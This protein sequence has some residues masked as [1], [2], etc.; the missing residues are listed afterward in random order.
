[1]NPLLRD[2]VS[3]GPAQAAGMKDGDFVK[4]VDG[5]PIRNMAGVC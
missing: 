4:E 3:D 2:V 1:M 5:K